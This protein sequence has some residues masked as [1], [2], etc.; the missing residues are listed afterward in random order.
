MLWDALECHQCV[1]STNPKCGDPFDTNLKP[2]ECTLNI[3]DFLKGA[4]SILSA[5]GNAVASDK[6]PEKL[7][8]N[9]DIT[10]YKAVTASGSSD[11]QKIIFR[12]CCPSGEYS[13][14]KLLKSNESFCETCTSDGCNG[15]SGVSPNSLLALLAVAVTALLVRL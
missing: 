12:G 6:H 9:P 14:C 15:A 8:D 11:E 10:C 4:D 1:S 2:S 5:L 3:F 13:M 7:D